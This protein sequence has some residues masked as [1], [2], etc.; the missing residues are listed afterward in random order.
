[1][2]CSRQALSIP[3]HNTCNHPHFTG[4]KGGGG[5]RVT[6]TY[7]LIFLPQ[8]PKSPWRS[9]R[10]CYLQTDMMHGCKNGRAYAQSPAEPSEVLGTPFCSATASPTGLKWSVGARLSRFN[11]RVYRSGRCWWGFSEGRIQKTSPKK[12]KP[13]NNKL[14]GTL[15]L[16]TILVNARA[17]GLPMEHVKIWL[18]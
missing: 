4:R 17:S 16:L 7:Q 15:F 2:L 3:K 13:Q 6:L 14:Y 18:C 10:T 9:S 8:V 11:S 5:G 12:K 1:M